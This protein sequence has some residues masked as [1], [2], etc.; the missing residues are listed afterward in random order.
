MKGNMFLG[1]ARGSVGDVTF[2]RVKN[3][4]VA[5]ARNRNPNNPRTAAQ[6]TQRTRFMSAVKFFSRGVQNLFQFA[7]ED[8][9]PQE[10]D[11]NAFMRANAGK[12]IY[13]TKA[14]FDNTR[15]PALGNWTMTKGSL[16]SFRCSV[17]SSSKRLTA[18]TS[19]TGD[20]S[21]SYTSVGDLSTALIAGG[22]FM[23]GDVITMVNIIT[24]AAL[25]DDSNPVTE[26]AI[27]P[28]W[29]IN[30]FIVKQSDST[31]LASMNFAASTDTSSGFIKIQSSLALQDI[32]A[33]VMIHSRKTD[34]KVL[35]S[36][37]DIVNTSDAEAAI[38]LGT[39]QEWLDNVLQTWSASEA[40]VLEGSR[41][42]N[43]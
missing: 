8:K 2:S 24:A 9:R 12:G 1:Y 41:A 7:F 16:Q 23:E 36:S 14:D 5:R 22:D 17:D 43:K 39:K 3:Q 4:Q 37:Q 18:L 32:G 35:V 28:F 34:S 30:Q 11:Y 19:V 6:M 38:E 31:L 26:S 29:R 10:S 25:G 20:S 21:K 40:A 42:S 13:L 27:A 33:A 15:Y